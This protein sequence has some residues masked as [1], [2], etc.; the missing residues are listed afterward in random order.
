MGVEVLADPGFGALPPF[1]GGLQ[2]QAESFRGGDDGEPVEGG[3]GEQLDVNLGEWCTAVG[4]V[5]DQRVERG[6]LAA[7]G[8]RGDGRTDVR[9]GSGWPAQ[10]AAP[11]DL[12]VA[13]AAVDELAAEVR[14]VEGDGAQTAQ[15]PVDQVVVDVGEFAAVPYG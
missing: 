12:G 8:W 6:L 13:D 2:W 15:E 3:H 4:Y 9:R 5:G 14:H 11:L 10:M 1:V 7:G